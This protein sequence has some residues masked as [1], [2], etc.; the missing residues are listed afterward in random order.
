MFEEHEEVGV[1]GIW[2]REAFSK[3]AP[4]QRFLHVF[5]GFI[6]RPDPSAPSARR[7][8]SYHYA[9]NLCP[10]FLEAPDW[11]SSSY[12]KIPTRVPQF[13]TNE[14]VVLAKQSVQP[15]DQ[16]HRIA[17]GRRLMIVRNKME[18][19]LRVSCLSKDIAGTTKVSSV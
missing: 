3:E 9:I 1:S 6:S 16:N 4:H 8:G 5:G 18:H 2:G 14:E 13:V 15:P 17:S 19:T 10:T 7:F 11:L 12:V